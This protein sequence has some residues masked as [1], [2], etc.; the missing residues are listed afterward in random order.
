MGINGGS[1]PDLPLSPSS[2]PFSSSTLFL[3]A[4]RSLSLSR[5]H[6][7][8]F[9]T[10]S[11]FIA[12]ESDRAKARKSECPSFLF[13]V[14]VYLLPFGVFFVLCSPRRRQP[15]PPLLRPRRSAPLLAPAQRTPTGAMAASA[16]GDDSVVMEGYLTKSPPLKVRR[17]CEGWREGEGEEGR[18]RRRRER[19][20]GKG[21][22]KREREKERK[23]EE[24]RT[25]GD[26]KPP[27]LSLFFPS[28]SLSLS[29]P[30]A[31]NTTISFFRER[32][33]VCVHGE[34]RKRRV[35]RGAKRNRRRCQTAFLRPLP[36]PRLYCAMSSARRG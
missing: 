12:G 3:P 8:S 29:L 25:R 30:K 2:S 36:S 15:F 34:C 5:A 16:A 26:K 6:P 20:R 23:K 13:W 19:G 27:L 10:L 31:Q 17:T 33:C 24:E 14:S 1:L 21:E 28:L 32:G 9:I 18:E 35:K 11:L 22:E 7:S 4:A